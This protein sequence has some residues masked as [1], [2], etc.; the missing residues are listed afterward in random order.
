MSGGWRKALIVLRKECIDNLRDRRTMISSF[1]IAALGPLLFVVLMGFVL[2][3]ALGES[4]EALELTVTGGEHAPALIDFLSRN[5]TE[6]D[7]KAIDDPE[8]AVRNGD[9]SLVLRIPDNYAERFSAGRPIALDLIY[10]SSNFGASNSTFRRARGLLSQYAGTLG[11]L[12]LAMRGVDPA[13]VQPLSVQQ[14]DVSSPAE[15][16]LMLM[17]TLPY[18]LI[19]AVFM[20]GFYLAID[21]TAGERENKSLE[22]LLIQPVSRRALVLGKMGATGIFG[23]LVLLLF[24]IVFAFSV[25]FIPFHKVGMRLDFGALEGLKVFA[26]C[27]PLIVLAAGLLTLVA[28]YAKSYKE[29]QTYLSLL[30]LIPTMP[31]IV[32]QFLDLERTWWLM[33]IPS[34]SQATLVTQI[35]A[36]EPIE[37]LHVAL[38]ATVTLLVGALFA[39]LAIRLYSRERILG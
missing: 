35:I 6:L 16:A 13:V 33:M 31:V 10:D 27:L 20:G 37:P 19:L 14:V 22:S 4:E 29:A 34:Q 5:H 28:S 18:L 24:L 1:S 15:R 21:T 3:N 26:V 36:R 2:N 11:S 17:S 39:W 38:S 32:T 7:L 12:R 23:M 9:E 30:I 25:P 8:Q